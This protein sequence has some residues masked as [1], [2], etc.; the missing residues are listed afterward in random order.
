MKILWLVNIIMP[1]LAEHLNMNSSVFGGWLIGAKKAVEETENSLVI[2]CTADSEKLCGR[3]QINNTVYYIVKKSS[4]DNMSASFSKILSDENPDVIHIYGTEFAQCL[5]LSRVSLPQKTLVTIQGALCIYKDL[6]YADIPSK[7]CDDNI[8]HKILRK[9][10]KGGDS[11]QLQKNSF[12]E[13]AVYEEET[14]KNVKYIN[15]GSRWGNSV[16]RSVNPGCIT[17]NCN[18]ILRD[19]FYNSRLWNY[20]ECEKH[21]IYA[22]YSY[23]IKGFHKLLEAVSIVKNFYPDVKIKAVAGKQY[24]RNYNKIKTWLMNKAPDYQWYVQGLIEKYGLKDNIEFLGRLSEE[25]VKQELYNANVFVSASSIENQSTALGEAMI[26]GVPSIASFV[27]AIP[28]MIDNGTDGFTY[29]FN[30]AHLLADC[31]CS[32]FENPLLAK[33][34]SVKGHEHASKTYDREKNKNDLIN[35][36]NI[37]YNNSKSEDK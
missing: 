19:S 12:E 25:Q 29:P 5:A 37:I 33:Q 18:L 15:G 16:A 36:Y 6:A 21:T 34:F 9:L 22:L 23:P 11:I 17:M 26:L 8:Y 30:E 24:Y 31:I 13:R 7:I 4:M 27:G 3:Y 20:E 10:H 35:M 14:L 1:E 28:E 32:L 2:C